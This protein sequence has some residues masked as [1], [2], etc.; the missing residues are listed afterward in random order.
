MVSRL[1]WTIVDIRLRDTE[2]EYC[3]VGSGRPE[4]CMDSLRDP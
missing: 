3:Y 4:H 1:T 2:V